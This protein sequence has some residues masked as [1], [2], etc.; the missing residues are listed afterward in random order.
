MSYVSIFERV[1]IQKGLEQGRQ[2]GR[3]EGQ[4]RAAR[5][6]VLQALKVRFGEVPLAVLN[7][8][9]AE[10][11]LEELEALHRKAIVVGALGEF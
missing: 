3:Q 7:R 5:K 6:S 2:E 1:G 9:E 8:I 4:L 10:K 11:D